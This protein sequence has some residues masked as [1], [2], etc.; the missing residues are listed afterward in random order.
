MQSQG[1]IAEV[2]MLSG[3]RSVYI[4]CAAASIPG[5]GRYIMAH[6]EGSEAPLATEL[7]AADYRSSGFLAAPPV[8]RQ[9]MPGSVLALRGPSGHGFDLPPAARRVALMAFNDNPTRLLPLAEMAIRQGGAVALVCEGLTPDLPL[10]VEVHPLRAMAEVCRWADYAAFDVEIASL[11]ALMEALMPAGVSFPN[12][13][14]QALV[15]AAMPCG[16]LA[17]CG[18][19]TVRTARGPRLACVDGP[20]LDLRLLVRKR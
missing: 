6:E 5:P 9:W 8:P 20:V 12:G 15:H 1:T 11:A 18:V 2:C 17:D 19:C 13:A 14:A 16:G 7:F 3:Q 4:K 10:Q